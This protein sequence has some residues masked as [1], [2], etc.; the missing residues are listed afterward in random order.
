MRHRTVSS[1]RHGTYGIYDG[2]LKCL[3]NHTDSFLAEKMC[4]LEDFGSRCDFFLQYYRE[5]LASY[6][7]IFSGTEEIV[8]DRIVIC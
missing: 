3:R 4:E 1:G 2:K 5:K 6:D 7:K 8:R